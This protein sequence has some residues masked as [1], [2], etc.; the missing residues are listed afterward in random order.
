MDPSADHDPFADLDEQQRTYIRPRPGSRSPAPRPL[1][2]ED[3]QSSVVPD[4]PVVRHGLNPLV[5]L[6]NHLL[7]LVPSLR[8]SR[9]VPDVAELRRSLST[10][11][12]D[13]AA[14]ASAAGITPDRVMA[15]R[16]VLC[17]MIDEAAADTPW[18]GSGVWAS[19]SLLAIF[20]NETEGGEKV[21]QLMARLAEDPAAD[22]DLLELIYSA[23]VLGFEGRYRIVDNGA[24]QL[25][26]IRNKLAQI[27]RTQRGD[28]PKAL[29]QHWLGEVRRGEAG[30]RLAAAGGH[31]RHRRAA[32][33]DRLRR[34]LPLAGGVLRPGLRAD[35]GAAGR[36]AGHRAG[37]AGADPAPRAVPAVRHRGGHRGGP[38][39]RRSQRRDHPRRRRVRPRA[40]PRC[41]RSA[42]R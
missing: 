27:I 28:F 21:F 36:P 2:S 3:V 42:R 25:E 22:L 23:L 11:I 38:R 19:H 9:Q 10:S 4:G 35:P 1:P 41:W 18:G 30:A 12:R 39:R 17:T 31:R 29:A 37:G 40:V 8:G 13:F 24:A 26:A 6:A 32:P 15:A 33:H 14:A 7:L 16:Y 34:V 20:H 5:A